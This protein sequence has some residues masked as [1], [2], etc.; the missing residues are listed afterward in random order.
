MFNY[1]FNIY[2]LIGFFSGSAIRIWYGRK[3]KQEKLAIFHTEGLAVG[4]LACLW[5]IAI[6][7]PLFYMFTDWLSFADYNLPAWAGFIGIAAFTV[8]IWLLWRSHYDLGRNW[9]TTVEI[10]NGHTLVIGGIFNYI[11]HPMYA[12]HLLWGIAQI[13]LIH[14]WIAG[15]ASL[16]IMIPLCMLRIPFEEKELLKQYGDEYRQYMNKTGRVIPRFSR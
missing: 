9:S 4:L 2:Y 6:L 11:R 16:I 12:A 8:A 10:K 14:N 1:I 15:L 7:L 3:H 13:L 5:G